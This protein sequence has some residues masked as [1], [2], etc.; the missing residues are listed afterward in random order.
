MTLS[1]TIP[2]TFKLVCPECGVRIG[3]GVR[4]RVRALWGVYMLVE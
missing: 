4:V 1:K 3:V 2:G